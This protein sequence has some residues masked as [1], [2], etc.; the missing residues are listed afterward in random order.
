KRTPREERVRRVGRE[1]ADAARGT[2]VAVDHAA[3]LQAHVGRVAE[4][5]AAARLL[6][7]A[8]ADVGEPRVRRVVRNLR[9]WPD[10]LPDT[11]LDRVPARLDDVANPPNPF[12]QRAD[13]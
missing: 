9:Q 11:R 7:G 10:D 2:R 5:C 8:L 13:L 3:D 1:V 4:A 6:L 12:V